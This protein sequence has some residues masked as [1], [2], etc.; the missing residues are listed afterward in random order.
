MARRSIQSPRGAETSHGVRVKAAPRARESVGKKTSDEGR[1]PAKGK[2]TSRSAKSFVEKASAHAWR[3][4][5]LV[6]AETDTPERHI[7]GK[8]AGP[9]KT[10][11]LSRPRGDSSYAK[12]LASIRKAFDVSQETMAR[13]L[14]V[15]SRTVSRWEK[16]E[17]LP[18][19]LADI[20]KLSKLKQIMELGRK[21]YTMQGLQSLLAEAQPVFQGK[22]GIDLLAFGDFCSHRD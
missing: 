10:K 3:H 20:A 18:A 13:M 14:G 15:T 11:K 21:A 19:T 5:T 7:A 4:A 8:D 2:P 16:A 22:T 9:R 17:T 6:K 12:D 1:I